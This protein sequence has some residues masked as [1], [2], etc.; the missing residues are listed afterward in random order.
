VATS[1]AIPAN[2]VSVSPESW[3]R[4]IW[5]DLQP[6]PGRVSASLR[7]LLA[8][9]LTLILLLVWQIP[10]VSIALYFV[11]IVGRDSPSV[12]FRSGLFSILTLVASVATELALVSF[13]DNDPLA[14]VLGVAVVSFVAGMLVMA[15]SVPSLGSTWGFIFA[16]LI[17]TWERHLPADTLVKGSLWILAAT[18]I[19]TAC[20]IAV[21]YVFGS[22]NPAELLVEERRS[23]YKALIGMFTAYAEGAE[24]PALLS[25][26]TRVSRLA[27]AG[28]SGM[29]RLYNAIV[30][31]N[32]D[33]GTLPVGA[34]VRITMLAE[35]MDVSSAF[36][37][38]N[39]T[40]HDLKIRERCAQI[41]SEC[42]A[43]LED[44][45]PM[46]PEYVPP[47]PD[48]RPTM[49]DRVEANLHVI[50]S[51]PHDFSPERDKE[52]VALPSNKVSFVVPGAFKDRATW[53]FGLK[54][55]LCATLCYIVYWALD[56]PGIS[57]SVT[58]VLIAGLSTTGAFKQK[59][60]FRLAGALIGGLILGIG[61]TAFLFPEM[62][63]IT[64]LVVLVSVLAFGS[65]WIA[66]G[67]QF[68]YV[69]LQIIFAFYLVAFE[70]FSA[71]TQLT[72]ARDRLI[73]I[74]LALAVMW[75]VFDVLWP[76][77]TVTA[78]RQSLAS[79]LRSEAELFSTELQVTAHEKLI[80]KTDVFRDR[81]GK[82]MA[83]LRSMNDS[84]EY[85][86]G[87]DRQRHMDVAQRILRAALTSVS[88][89]WNE[90]AVLHRKDSEEFLSNPDLVELRRRMAQKLNGLAYKALQAEVPSD[91]AP[92]NEP[93]SLMFNLELI[94]H[95]IY[96]EYTKH[97]IRSLH[98]LQTVV[99][100]LETEV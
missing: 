21:E 62:D 42:Q 61:C 78:M 54:I 30:D 27:V 50:A 73:G 35:L 3:G 5:L 63:S 28:Q 45:T 7:I 47:G 75:I 37:Y 49:L 17:S 69:G 96:G 92:A 70:D 24:P 74:L 91:L 13:S 80:Q 66:N 60:L 52:L 90:V 18:S 56:W 22:R 87:I 85:E 43:L 94:N 89:L 46:H 57:T 67:R 95:P 100:G 19:A 55:S 31:R 83:A 40:S 93:Q 38:Q 11:F 33:A 39:P 86:F 53:Y 36:G 23:R 65:A 99:A 84:V 58:T 1:T 68:S 32:L 15:L 20:S 72:P 2:P 34:R 64:S 4:R 6:T 44:K 79:M 26:I 8:S 14:R 98:E 82:T 10:F 71:P 51:M 29:Q 97:T 81:V 48:V 9:I 88:M 59:I 25:A 12:S 41:A 76:V 16:T 77:R